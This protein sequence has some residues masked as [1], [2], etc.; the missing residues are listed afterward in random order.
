[1]LHVL[2]VLHMPAGEPLVLAVEP[3]ASGRHRRPHALK[4]VW[5]RRALRRLRALRQAPAG[6]T[7]S[8]RRQPAG[9]PQPRLAPAN[10]PVR[11]QD[12]RPS[13]CPACSAGRRH[14]VAQHRAGRLAVHLASVVGLLQS[15][16]QS[17][18]VVGD[19]HQPCRVV[20]LLAAPAL[21][22]KKS[23]SLATTATGRPSAIA[24]RSSFSNCLH[25]ADL[26]TRCTVIASRNNECASVA[27]CR[28]VL[29][30]SAPA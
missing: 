30:R 12:S 14:Q 25:K 28:R 26:P 17:Q 10:D 6:S 29:E 13:S 21:L 7:R 18:R 15:R 22:A 9:A 20:L 16:R 23:Q 19:G 11:P 27:E 2:G 3:D 8:P 5:E 24:V 4:P 1:M